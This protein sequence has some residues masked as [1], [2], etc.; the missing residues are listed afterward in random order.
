[1]NKMFMVDIETTG[2]ILRPHPMNLEEKPS[3]ILQ[4]AF[5]ELL[6]SQEANMWQPKNTYE[7]LAYH[8]MPEKLNPFQEKFQKGLFERCEKSRQIQDPLEVRKQMLEFFR[9]C[10]VK[11]PL[12]VVLCGW[13]AS[14]FDIPFLNRDQFLHAPYTDND[15]DQ[16]IGDHHYRIYELG[17]AIQFA[18]NKLRF[19]VDR[20]DL[21]K[22][23]EDIGWSEMFKA[24]GIDQVAIKTNRGEH[25]AVY[26]C[27]N[28]TAILNGLLND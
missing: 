1:M 3:K 12:G 26:D 4:I 6:W 2:T 16:L 15:T 17:G 11:P 23:A 20:K 13:N 27:Y 19:Q 22:K 28:Q 5:L 14:N 7:W 25:D 9:S 24:F 10:G 21:C 18:E 8:E